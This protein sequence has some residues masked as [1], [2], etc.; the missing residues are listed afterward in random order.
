MKKILIFTILFSCLFIS[1][2]AY[3][4]PI[5]GTIGGAGGG[6]A[7]NVEN[8]VYGAGWN[9]DNVNAPSQNAVYDYLHLLDTND[10][11]DIDTIDAV[12]WATKA[13]AA[14]T[15]A[16]VYQPADA[17]LTTWAGITPS[18]NLQTFLATPNAANFETAISA[19][20]FASNLL[21]YADAAAVLSGIGGIGP[22][23]I[24][25]CTGA[26]CLDGSADGGTYVRMYDGNS[27]YTQLSPGDSTANLTWTFPTAY[28][29]GTYLL[30]SSNAGVLST[31]NAIGSIAIT[32]GT[33][34]KDAVWATDNT[35]CTAAGV[36]I[37]CCTGAGTGTCVSLGNSTGDLTLSTN[38]T[39]QTG[40]VTLTGNVAGSTLVLPSGSLTLGTMAAET[41]TDYVTKATY[42]A[43][44]VLY[45]TSDN[46]PVALSVTEQT[47]V[48]RATGGNISA[49]AID[50][51]LSAVSGNDD[52]VPSAKA[53]KAYVDSGSKTLTNTTIDANGTGN[54]IKAY[55]Y[56]MLTGQGFKRLGAGMT[57]PATTNTDF[58]YG[59]PKFADDVD[60]ATNWMDWVIQVPPEIDTAVDLTATLTFYLGGADT[61]DHDYVVSMCNPAA[62][63][64]AA[65]TPGNAV[66]LAYTADG[67]GA[68]GDV[69]QTT[70]TTL[71]DWKS[72]VTAG[73]MLLIRLARD[74]DDGTNDSST[75]D[76]YPLV[77]TIKYGWTN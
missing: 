26:P 6:A 17:D 58:N 34:G 41:A 45:A 49:L 16:G 76:S 69:E 25:N 44:T 39:V 12:L 57:T 32:G 30:Q 52:T 33:N 46:T 7:A 55:S 40:A 53:T 74:G 48:G 23:G 73:R 14:H 54:T 72:N 62:S 64:A 36:P 18:A 20:A 71:T 4:G 47:V 19:G 8:D 9:G 2:K 13:D 56:M 70:E 66:N 51:D 31:T 3:S 24:V 77:L 15:H 37:A 42:D 38:L 60:E 67:S 1:V 43:H 59:L 50:S 28:P 75:V 10:D 29:A 35:M 68:D 27:H 21:G 65:C 61:N 5:S 11:G 63:A 22:A